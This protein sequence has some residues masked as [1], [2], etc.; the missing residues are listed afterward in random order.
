MR[1]FKVTEAQVADF[2]SDGF[3]QVDRIISDESVALLRERFDSFLPKSMRLELLL[4]RLIGRLIGIHLRTQ[5]SYVTL[6]SPTGVL[7]E[8]FSAQILGE[9]APL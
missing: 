6:G 2:H 7:R 1:E 9:H 4:M 5:D 3:I 8:S